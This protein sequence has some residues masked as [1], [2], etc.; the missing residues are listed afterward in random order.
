DQRMTRA[1]ERERGALRHRRDADERD[2][3]R[4]LGEALADQIRGDLGE[5]DPALADARL[6]ARARRDLER[7]VEDEAE[8][9]AQEPERLGALAAV[10]HLPHDLGLADACGV[11]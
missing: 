7:L 1:R 9:G 3:A 4:R 6:A 10:A 2:R 11:E 5:R 8:H